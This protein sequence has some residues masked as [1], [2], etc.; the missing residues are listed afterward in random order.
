MPFEKNKI[1]CDDCKT[2]LCHF[3]RPHGP[4]HTQRI[5]DLERSQRLDACA[6]K[7]IKL[8]TVVSGTVAVSTTLPD[9][10]RQISEID[11][12]GDT[13]CGPMVIEGSPTWIEALETSTVCEQ[14]FTTQMHDLK[15]DA[16]FMTEMFVMVHRRLQEASRHML[17]LGRL[18]ST[19]RVTYFLADMA[20]Q[21][22]RPGPVHLPMSR[23][24][25]A[26]FLGLN[27]ETVSRVFSRLRKSGLF[28]FETP[29]DFVMPDLAAVERRLP[30]PL[31]PSPGATGER[32]YV[33]TA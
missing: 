6:G 25:I 23:E 13:I 30:V 14:D 20:L 3:A 2:E 28:R 18:D 21:S 16:A 10:R 12:A 9:G 24:D 17:M 4:V 27:A 19:E 8:W 31:A 29:T 33:E 26:D 22:P 5:I 15:D 7:C 11:R 32:K 1:P